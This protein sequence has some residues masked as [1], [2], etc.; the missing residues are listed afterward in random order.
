MYIQTLFVYELLSTFSWGDGVFQ[1]KETDQGQ[2]TPG[3]SGAHPGEGSKEHSRT[4]AAGVEQKN[5]QANK[6]QASTPGKEDLF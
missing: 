1:N 2:G 4:D 5:R 3:S 6:R